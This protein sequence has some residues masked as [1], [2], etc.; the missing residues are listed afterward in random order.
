MVNFN[1]DTAEFKQGEQKVGRIREAVVDALQTYYNSDEI[2][3]I[4]R[5]DGTIILQAAGNEATIETGPQGQTHV[6]FSY[7]RDEISEAI[8]DILES[9]SN[10]GDS[11]V[12]LGEYEDADFNEVV[13]SSGGSDGG[14]GFPDRVDSAKGRSSSPEGKSYTGLPQSGNVKVEAHDDGSI[15]FKPEFTKE[16]ANYVGA[17]DNNKDKDHSPCKDCAHFIEGGGCHLVQGDI[18]PNGYCTELFSDISISGHKHPN[19]VEIPITIWGDGFNW[20]RQD[21]QRFAQSVKNKIER[22][23]GR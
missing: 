3:E 13:G 20:T 17:W 7:T 21:M 8:K 23:L 16:Q 4:T 11:N 22:K 15:T 10:V 9:L 14:M 18:E 19:G 6:D 1:G 12:G 5:R 2:E